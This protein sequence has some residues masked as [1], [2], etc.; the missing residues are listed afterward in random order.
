MSEGVIVS[1][2]S[3]LYR[4]LSGH[5]CRLHGRCS[6]DLLLM[7]LPTHLCG[8]APGQRA[9]ISQSRSNSWC[10]T[11]QVP[12]RSRGQGRDHQRG[13][14]RKSGKPP[15]APFVREGARVVIG[16]LL[17]AE[18]KALVAELGEATRVL[19]PRRTGRD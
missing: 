9:Q 10:Q 5:D 15:P 14:P 11:R 6:T 12:G 16:D 2:D 18:G 3:W 13:R 19:P 17:E 8:A 1:L 4:G 7:H